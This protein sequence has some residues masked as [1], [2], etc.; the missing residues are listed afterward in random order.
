MFSVLFCEKRFRRKIWS[1]ALR[2]ASSTCSFSKFIPCFNCYFLCGS[3]CILGANWCVCKTGSDAVLQKTLDYACGAG[4]DCNPIKSTGACYN[5]NSVKAHCDYAVNSYFQK[6]GQAA[7]T[8]D[9]AGTAQAVTTDPSKPRCFFLAFIFR[10]VW[11]LPNSLF[12]GDLQALVVVFSH[13]APGIILDPSLC[14]SWKLLLSIFFN[15]LSKNLCTSWYEE[16]HTFY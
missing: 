3:T 11:W 10:S 13:R 1:F 8:C 6:K 9:F 14:F 4:A 2:C 16:D 7:G 5:P 15:I 12:I